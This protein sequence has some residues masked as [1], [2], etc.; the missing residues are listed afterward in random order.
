MPASM[1]SCAHPQHTRG[2]QVP[3]SP[4]PASWDPAPIPADQ[5]TC[6]PHPVFC[7]SPSAFRHARSHLPG[8]TCGGS[9]SWQLKTGAG[10]RRKASP[11]VCWALLLLGF[12]PAMSSPGL[13]DGARRQLSTSPH[14]HR[15][16]TAW[17]LPQHPLPSPTACAG[18]AAGHTFPTDH[19]SS[20]GG[21]SDPGGG[22]LSSPHSGVGRG[23]PQPRHS[24]S[25]VCLQ[26]K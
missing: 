22:I 5:E 23:R 15:P 21:I 8:R 11:T 9:G 3:H 7:P 14:P 26:S 13:S 25:L 16:L 2:P 24:P 4:S 20:H 1:G 18:V 6:I 17:L 19:G 12:P 10:R